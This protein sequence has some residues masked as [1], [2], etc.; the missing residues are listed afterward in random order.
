MNIGKHT[1]GKLAMLNPTEW[2]LQVE[3][4]YTNN[5]PQC[6]KCKGTIIGTVHRYDDGYGFLWMKC[7]KCSEEIHFSRVRIPK[8]LPN[9]IEIL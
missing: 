2:A 5:N 6:P 7:A 1:G 4:L 3:N 9:T 8:N